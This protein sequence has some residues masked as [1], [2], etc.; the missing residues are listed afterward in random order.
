MLGGRPLALS[1]ARVSTGPCVGAQR[2]ARVFAFRVTRPVPAA[3]WIRFLRMQFAPHAPGV[4][5]NTNPGLGSYA[6]GACS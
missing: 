3:R 1:D 4:T 5:R 6:F 2:D